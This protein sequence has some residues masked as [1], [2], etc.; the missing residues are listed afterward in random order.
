KFYPEVFER[1][2]KESRDMGL[3]QLRQ[4]LHE[5]VDLG[6]VLP[7]VNID[8][9]VTMFYYTSMGFLR[10]QTKLVLPDGVT[11]QEAFAYTVVNFFRGLATLK[12][13]E[14]IDAYVEARKQLHE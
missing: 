4:R 1:I 9:A 10:R 8:L 6:L 13:V 7:D 14:Q 12:G 2:M 11:E 3:A 5:L